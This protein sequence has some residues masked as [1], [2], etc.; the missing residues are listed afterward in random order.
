MICFIFS[1]P[2]H[3][4]ALLEEAPNISAHDRNILKGLVKI[5]AYF[6]EATDFVQ[7]ENIPSAG[8]VLPCVKGLQHH[9]KRCSSMYHSPFAAALKTSLWAKMPYYEESE[10]YL[11]ASVLDP[12]FKLHWSQNN[13]EKKRCN[14]VL[15][16]EAG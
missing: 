13:T 3:K 6:I 15:Q 2:E 5:L 1:I 11:L 9:L 10:P 7:V 14:E 8:Y 4:L 16:R 12:C